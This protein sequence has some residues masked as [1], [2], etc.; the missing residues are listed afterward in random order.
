MWRPGRPRRP[1]VSVSTTNM[2]WRGCCWG[3]GSIAGGGIM[4][5]PEGACGRGCT[6]SP[7][8]RHRPPRPRWFAFL[9]QTSN[10]LRSADL[11]P[12][13]PNPM[14]SWRFAGHPRRARGCS[15]GDSAAMGTPPASVDSVSGSGRKTNRRPVTFRGR[16]RTKCGFEVAVQGNNHARLASSSSSSVRGAR[17]VPL[18]ITLQPSSKVLP[19]ASNNT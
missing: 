11:H 4:G 10:C 12:S 2:P 15:G 19:S 14:S 6:I 3:C 17:A 1:L 9:S 13:A 16:I 5:R 7:Q 18:T 8:D